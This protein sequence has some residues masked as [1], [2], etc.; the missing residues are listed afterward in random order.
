MARKP[1]PYFQSTIC[2]DPFEAGLFG[3]RIFLDRMGNISSGRSFFLHAF[4]NR[5]PRWNRSLKAGMETT[6]TGKE[7]IMSD[8]EN[9]TAGIE[10]KAVSR[11]RMLG[12]LGLTA[13]AAYT[14]PTLATVRQAHAS[15]GS[16]GGSGGRGGGFGGRGS[17]GSGG[18][19]VGSGN[20]GRDAQQMFRRLGW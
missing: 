8:N 19:S 9:K 18:R 20:I 14:V 1:A 6:S 2:H 11:R 13:V 17:R 7:M 4:S 3:R 10:E 5:F 15:G 16:G 12:I